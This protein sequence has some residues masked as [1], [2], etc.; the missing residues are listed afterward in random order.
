M[1]DDAF[2]RDLLAES[3]ADEGFAVRTAT[4]GAEALAQEAGWPP[5]VI[6]VDLTPPVTDGRGFLRERA[7]D[8]HLASV[9]V[10]VMSATDQDERLGAAFQRE[11]LDLGTLLDQVERLA[12]RSPSRT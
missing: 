1:E 2:V 10:V 3:L 9:P 6:V 11:P 8:G 7:R 4:S 5:D 12:T